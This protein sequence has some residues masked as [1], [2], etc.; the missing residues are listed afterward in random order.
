[1][2]NVA[3]QQLLH[4][5]KDANQQLVQDER[6]NTSQML[7]TDTRCD[8]ARR[9][10]LTNQDLS[11]HAERHEYATKSPIKT[12]FLQLRL[13]MFGITDSLA[14]ANEVTHNAAQHKR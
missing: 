3:A 9:L 5:E 4:Q 10:T 8:D 2:A 13:Y 6:L 12:H 14:S 1:M 11:Q 7:N